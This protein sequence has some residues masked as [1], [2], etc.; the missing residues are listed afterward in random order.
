MEYLR[1]IWDFE[2]QPGDRFWANSKWILPWVWIVGIGFSFYTVMIIGVVPGINTITISNLTEVFEKY[3]NRLQGS[4][5][6][7]RRNLPYIWLAIA[8][9]AMTIRA[10]IIINSYY[11]TKKKMGEIHFNKFF[12]TFL[13]SFFIST[14]TILLLTLISAIVYSIGYQF[15]WMGNLIHTSIDGLNSIYA[16][17]APYSLNIKNYWLAIFVL[18]LAASLPI[19][20][21]HYLS[22][23]LRLLW[24][25][26]HKAHH[27]PEFLFP[28][29]APS[30]NI[31]FLEVLLAI[32]GVIFFA[33]LS[34]MIYT[35]PLI[36]ELAIWYTAKLS[37]EPF[38]HSSIHY[39]IANSKWIRRISMV[40]G[41]TGVYH[42]V[43]HS[44]Y[45]RDQN[46]NFGPCPFMIWDRLFGTF[47]EPYNEV[48]PLGL[49]N[50]PPISWSPMKIVFSGFAQIAYEW[51]SNPSWRIRLK[52]IFGDV[53]YLPPVTKDFL[54][55]ENSSN[56][57]SN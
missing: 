15:D 41:D 23:K 36:F 48:P 31:A 20:I 53:Y 46:V 13:L 21:V 4:P 35:E 57:I 47:R 56:G 11:L 40:F 17:L 3:F 22:H 10:G 45:E 30:N 39:D 52:I 26:A 14:S 51:K 43:H 38:N 16:R 9:V 1:K 42:L 54:V 12:T 25:L 8:I 27:C 49:T 29:A 33:V 50:Q 32:P 18:L 34:S 7:F 6:S 19:Y 44:A 24:L 5:S 37:I 28:I 55:L 2:I